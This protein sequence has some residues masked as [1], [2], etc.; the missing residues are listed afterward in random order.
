M[1]FYYMLRGQPPFMSLGGV[2]A[3]VAAALRHERPAIPRAWDTTLTRLLQ[4]CW[5][6]S[7]S[8][9]PSFEQASAIL[10][11]QLLRPP[12][13]TVFVPITSS[14]PPAPTHPFNP[15]HFHKPLLVRLGVHAAEL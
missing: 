14:S 10:S 1:I 2:D 12:H 13:A 3:A 9:R 6:D 8:T 11:P 5:S 15:R 7:G 4:N